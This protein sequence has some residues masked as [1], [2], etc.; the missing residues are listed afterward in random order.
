MITGVY[1]YGLNRIWLGRQIDREALD[2]LVELNRKYQVSVIGEGGEYETLV[3][4]APCFKKRISIVKAETVWEKDS[5]F[6][7]V[8][9]AVL[10]DKSV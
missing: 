6:L 1:A 9:K 10:Q 5:G 7:L 3:L 2:G 4:D 8:K